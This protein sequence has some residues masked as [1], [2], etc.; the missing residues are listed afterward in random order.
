MSAGLNVLNYVGPLR[1]NKN[2][3]TDDDPVFDIT[4]FEFERFKRHMTGLLERVS[5][6][7]THVEQKHNDIDD[8]LTEEDDIHESIDSN[9]TSKQE[10][11]DW[12]FDVKKTMDNLPRLHVESDGGGVADESPMA[13]F[14]KD[15]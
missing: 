14:S 7:S 2:A 8:T 6:I 9:E 1:K 4:P 12:V 15:L 10:E 11:S 5:R 3:P 13:N